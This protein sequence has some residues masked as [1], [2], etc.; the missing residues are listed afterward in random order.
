MM[1]K[2]TAYIQ[3]FVLGMSTEWLRRASLTNK[4]KMP[5]EN[6]H[7][8]DPLLLKLVNPQ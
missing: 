4:E 2:N 3:N 1:V 5:L 8:N 6:T 7:Q